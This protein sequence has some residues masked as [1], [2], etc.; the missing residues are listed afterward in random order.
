MKVDTVITLANN[1]NY[2]L[3]LETDLQGEDY[4]LSVLLDENN[5]P[6]QE[7]AV[8][9]EINQNGEVYSQKINNPL[10]LNQLLE[11]YRIQY[12]DDYEI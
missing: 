4:F 9:K 3:L 7:Y 5:E 10:I 12:E 11:D 1:K 2:L 8:L 6:T